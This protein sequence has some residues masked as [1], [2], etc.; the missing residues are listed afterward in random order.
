MV[1]LQYHGDFPSLLR[2]YLLVMTALP[3]RMALIYNGAAMS[4]AAPSESDLAFV[5]GS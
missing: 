4:D 3:I 5:S 1:D 2:G